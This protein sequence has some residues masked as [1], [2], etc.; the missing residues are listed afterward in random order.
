M[1]YTSKCKVEL[2]GI[3]GGDPLAPYAYSG[4]QINFACSP[5]RM[6][7]KPVSQPLITI[8]WPRVNLN[9]SSL[10]WL[11]S[12]YDPFSRVPL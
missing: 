5:L 11:E 8:P 7:A 1:S 2:P 6:L 12:N 4:A 10:F 3:L 9:G